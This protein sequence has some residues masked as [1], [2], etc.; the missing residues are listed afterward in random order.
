M[1]KKLPSRP[2]LDH[3]RRQAKKLLADLAAGKPDAVA[4][5]HKHLPAAKTMSAT[6]VARAH[7]RL[8]DAQSAIARKSGF[9]GWPHLSR[10]VEQLR[11]LEGNWSFARLEVDGASMPA[12][13]FRTSRLLIDGDR[14]RTETPDGNYEGI[15]NINVE[16]QPHE[17]AIE[18]VEGPEA[19]NHNHGIFRFN[20]D[21]LEICL[22]LN[23]Q[24]RPGKFGA[25]Q[26]SGHAYEILKRTER[27]RPASVTGGTAAQPKPV[28]P[29]GNPAPF[30]C[31]ESPTLARLQGE[32]TAV[33]IIRDG[34]D[35]PATVLR[36]ALRSAA[37]NEIKITIGGMLAIHA[38]VELDESAMPMHVDYF[39]LSGSA[40]D[41]RQ[42]GLFKW[43]G[44]EACFCIAAPGDPRPDGFEAP[45]G[46]G[47]SF[48]QWRRKR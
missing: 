5:I 16:A 4:T 23:G 3:L 40:K 30:E 41:T 36:T 43:D 13:T 19:G 46:S 27:T 2:N 7:F 24:Q 18:F 31:H 34:L 20:D 44:E 9:A 33:K 11:A 29:T 8:A 45:R 47:R 35:L 32:W 25:S 10:H 38:L 1:Q 22:D 14:F 39:N 6:D 15:F 28:A 26:G 12:E 37:Q 48:S 21:Q 42:H 17:I